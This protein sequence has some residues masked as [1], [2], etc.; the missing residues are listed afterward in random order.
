MN[1]NFKTEGVGNAYKPI[2]DGFFLFLPL[3]WSAIVILPSF[4]RLC[5]FALHF[6]Q[7]VAILPL[8]FAYLPLFWPLTMGKIALIGE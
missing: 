7:V 6:S 8:I 5:D 3:L 2:K 1:Y 4:F